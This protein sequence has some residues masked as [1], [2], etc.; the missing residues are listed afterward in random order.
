[1]SKPALALGAL[2]VLT[3]TLAACAT[4]KEIVVKEVIKEVV[5]ESDADVHEALL[6]I[7]RQNHDYAHWG[8]EGDEG[9]GK[10]GT[11]DSHYAVCGGGAFQSPIEIKKG[12]A[13]SHHT[14]LHIEY[15]GAEVHAINNGHTVQLNVERDDDKL[16]VNG[17]KYKLIQMHFHA[18]SEHVVDGERFP[19]EAH[20]V[21]IDDYD[22]LAVLGLPIRV[23]AE[24]AILKPLFDNMPKKGGERIDREKEIVD[25]PNLVPDETHFFH[26]QGSLTTP[27]C[28]ENVL[29]FVLET[30]V[31]ISQAQVD[32]FLAVVHE[33]ARPVQQVDNR[34]LVRNS[35]AGEAAPAAGTTK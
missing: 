14:D 25:L 18:P 28:T 7:A 6:E 22:H 19:M 27:P 33:N 16:M 2:A 12:E 26:Y 17:H 20:L 9:P 1:M 29:W 10:W 5:K 3:T 24:N 35:V 34:I 15:V 11:L 13:K 31:E 30:P 8:Y 21:H 4:E 23:G 32:A